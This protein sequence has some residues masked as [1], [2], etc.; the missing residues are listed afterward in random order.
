V[1]FG[2]DASCLQ[3]F[4]A[5]Q[6]DSTGP[7]VRHLAD[8]VHGR[9]RVATVSFQNIPGPLQTLQ[10]ARSWRISLPVS[11]ENQS[12]RSQ[13]LVLDDGFLGIT[14]LYAPPPEDHKVE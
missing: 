5:E 7:I 3:S 2:W 12:A 9:S 1:P 10:T 11:S 4:L 6:G 8:E 14:T 13:Y